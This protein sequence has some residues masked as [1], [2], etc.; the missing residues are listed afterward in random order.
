M[1]DPWTRTGPKVGFQTR[2]PILER[3]IEMVNAGCMSV[4][5]LLNALALV[6]LPVL[7]LLL[8]VVPG[9]FIFTIFAIDIL[10]GP[11]AQLSLSLLEKM[12]PQVSK[13]V[14]NSYFR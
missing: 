7:L 5:M 13:L 12:I 8:C 1:H 3:R 14:F 2:I 4:E 9:G 6:V 11:G 10:P